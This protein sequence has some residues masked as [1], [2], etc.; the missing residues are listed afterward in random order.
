MNAEPSLIHC[1]IDLDAPGKQT[2]FLRLPH[3][4]HRSA[5]GWIPI[6]IVTIARG[7]GPVVLLV[8][9]NHGD[10]YEG[11][12]AL[13][14]LIRRV[15]PEDVNGQLI[16]LPAINY[17]AVIAGTRVSPIDEGNLNR[18]FP[19]KAMGTPTQMI[20]HF[21]STMLAPRLDYCL[22]IHS[23]GTS[24]NYGATLLSGPPPADAVERGRLRTLIEALGLP[25]TLVFRGGGVTGGR[26]LG[27]VV[28]AQG[29]TSF[30]AEIG[31][32]G[33]VCPASI[34]AAKG[35]VA[36]YLEAT[37]VW[38]GAPSAAP[39]AV[40]RYI[41]NSRADYLYAMDNGVFE[42]FGALGE[43]VVAGQAAGL[44]HSTDTPWRPA[45][46]LRYPTSGTV[47]CIRPLA[48]VMRGDCLFQTGAPWPGAFD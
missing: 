26:N 12:I 17:P 31:G 10:E 1:E 6:P 34:A 7:E 39:P 15:T 38:C 46:E 45:V 30:A 28:K 35:M 23:G 18:E 25:Q 14:D 47:V 3:S 5:Y 22:D 43:D 42:P 32:G 11:Q 37:G 19:G 36:R 2:G 41:S 44:I 8:A 27:G 20:A 24:L 16:I 29:A 33:G 40:T 21:V 9:G 13:M 48:P 4:V